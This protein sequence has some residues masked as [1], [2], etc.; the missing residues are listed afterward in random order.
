[1]GLAGV[2]KLRKF[3]QLRDLLMV[4]EDQEFKL[5]SYD[6]RNFSIMITAPN[7]EP[8]LRWLRS[9]IDTVT[10]NYKFIVLN[11]KDPVTGINILDIE[12]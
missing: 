10:K 12:L 6:D 5:C 3:Y 4:Y 7:N 2:Y 9:Y 8:Y 1:M 11:P